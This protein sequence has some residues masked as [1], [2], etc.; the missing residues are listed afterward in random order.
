MKKPLVCSVN[1]ISVDVT[2]ATEISALTTVVSS[3]Q[4]SVEMLVDLSAK[5]NRIIA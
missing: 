5:Q 1:A 2:T 4:S 3:L